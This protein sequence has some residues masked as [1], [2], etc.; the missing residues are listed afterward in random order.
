MH[1]LSG[2]LT[3]HL[4]F[5]VLLCVVTASP[6]VLAARVAAGPPPTDPA[7]QASTSPENGGSAQAHPAPPTPALRAQW[8]A[9]AAVG[10]ALWALDAKDGVFVDT[11]TGEVY[12]GLGGHA[13]LVHLS[14]GRYWPAVGQQ[15]LGVL[16]DLN[17]LADS[18]GTLQFHSLAVAR[19]VLPG[20]GWL[21]RAGLG[22]MA[23]VPSDDEVETV[24]GLGATVGVGYSF[25]LCRG[26]G[27]SLELATQWGAP[28]SAASEIYTEFT[29]AGL[30][31][32]LALQ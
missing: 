3:S 26:L 7:G 23:L 10:Y 12:G 2:K 30:Q 13:P 27:A 15:S 31:V 8:V 20:H 28:L 21:L 9:E 19:R 11:E 16:Y 22:V 29:A 25:E 18:T 14:L 24:T 17:V 6:S 5:C 32:G 4:L 1:G